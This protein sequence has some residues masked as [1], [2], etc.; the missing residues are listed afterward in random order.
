MRRAISHLHANAVAYVALFIALSGT[1][2]A[3]LSLPAGSVGKRQLQNRSIDPVK[4]DPSSIGA[5]IRAWAD[6]SWDGAWRIRAS[7]RDIRITRIALG[8]V[9]TWQHTRF[10]R[11]CFASVTPERNVPVS[12][13]ASSAEGYVTTSF[14]GPRGHLEIDGMS[15]SGTHQVQ[16]FSLLIVCPSPGS[17]KVG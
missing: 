16:D 13:G 14:D 5:T 11:N 9:V 7:S 6:V 4:L 12:G 8:E 17:Q 3:A 10:A 15:P 2:Y 1:S